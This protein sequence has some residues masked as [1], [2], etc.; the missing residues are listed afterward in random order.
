[1]SKKVVHSIIQFSFFVSLVAGTY[2]SED[3]NESISLGVAT[4]SSVLM[5]AKLSYL[6]FNELIS[7]HFLFY[8]S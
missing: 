5:M 1:M 2:L 7:L 4:I 8:I 6:P 3:I